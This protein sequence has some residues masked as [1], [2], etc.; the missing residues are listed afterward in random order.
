MG[1]VRLMSFPFTTLALGSSRQTGERPGTHSFIFPSL[2]YS[3]LVSG[4]PEFMGVNG[5][6][7]WRYGNNSLSLRLLMQPSSWQTLVVVW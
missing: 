5:L 6:E 1:A 2:F 4:V 3:S 7:E